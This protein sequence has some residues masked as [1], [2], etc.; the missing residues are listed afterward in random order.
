M[1]VWLPL[2]ARST[3]PHDRIGTRCAHAWVETRTGGDGTS[4][5]S[6]STDNVHWTVSA[7]FKPVIAHCRH[8]T[9]VA[10]SRSSDV[11]IIVASTHHDA[12]RRLGQR[13]ERWMASMVQLGALLSRCSPMLLAIRRAFA[14]LD[15][16]T[17]AKLRLW[18]LAS[19]EP[20]V[21]AV[22]TP[23]LRWPWSRGFPLHAYR[24]SSGRQDSLRRRELP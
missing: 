2:R 17:S 14:S 6:R 11:L 19:V 3:P 1:A 12:R 15:R 22:L 24:C 7:C 8:Q 4:R 18:R 23:S 21:P 5:L 10:G 20:T 9:F 16:R 13:R